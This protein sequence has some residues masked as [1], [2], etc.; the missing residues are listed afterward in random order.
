MENNRNF[1]IT[2]AL[3]VLILSLWQYFYVLPHSEAQ[4]EAARIEEQRLAEQKKAAEAASPG[5]SDT[6]V[7]QQ[8]AIPNAPNAP[9]TDGTTLASREQAL[10][11]TK[12]VRI[13]TPSLEGSINL[14]GAR[15]D[16]LKLKHYR[17]TVDKNSPE[18]EL[19]NPAALPTGY[20]AEIGFIG[21]DKTGTVPGPETVWTVDGNATLTPATPVTLSFTNDKGLTFK[22]TF[23]VDGDYM[24]TVSD[25]VQNSGAAAITLSNYGRVT[26]FDKPAVASIYVL[27][28]GLIGVTGTEGL[29]EHTYSSIEEDK[30][31]TPSKS[32]DGWLGITD[33]Y[34]AVT[35]VPTE[36]QQF[37][38][39]YA[40]FEDGRPRYQA[41]FLTDPITVDAGQS[42]TVESEI[43]AGAKEVAKVNAYAEDRN[44]RLFDRLI[45]WGWFIWITKPMFYLID[46]M[47]KFFGNFGLAILATTVVV[48]AAFYPLANKSYASM[49]NMKKVQPKMLEIREK[50][51]DDKMKQQQAMMELYKT[52]KI[53]PLAGCWPVALQIPVFFALYKVLYIT[54]EMRH[55]PFFGW[56]QD[57]AAPDPTSIFNLF[58]LIPIALPD[59]LMIGVWPLIM[60]LT[61]FLQMRMNPTPP[62]PTQAMI[63]TWMPVVFT[64]MMAG[65]PAGLVIYWAW[66]NLLSIIQQGVIMKRQGAKIELWDNLVALFRKKPSPAE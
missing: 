27:H 35:L 53:N 60:G 1:F 32:T 16:D 46:T 33:K 34:W 20:Y 40:Y 12:R 54:I 57:L 24:F 6:P 55:A 2:I 37:Q 41:D 11:S 42:A 15:L 13:D 43:F 65:F 22:R 38:P 25:T 26:R 31:F 61:M 48:K 10:A 56:I 45:D 36:K 63:F 44:I 4:R 62:D 64:F 14:A 21:S 5:G 58:G 29:Q 66:N 52:E 17:L 28:E 8:G 7:P 59:M 39:R 47:Y 51:A 50:Y 9:G 19:L 18:I 23:S 3:S 30:Q 49:A